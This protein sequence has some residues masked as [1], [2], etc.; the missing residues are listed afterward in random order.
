MSNYLNVD[1]NFK[2]NVI[3]DDEDY[4][5]NIDDFDYDDEEELYN[6]SSITLERL[7]DLELHKTGRALT[8]ARE[9]AEKE[10]ENKA[11]KKERERLYKTDKK[12]YNYIGE[13]DK[14]DNRI[15]TRLNVRKIKKL[16]RYNDITYKS[17]AEELDISK[18]TIDRKMNLES[19][20]TINEVIIISEMLG[21]DINELIYKNKH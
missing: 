8:L 14:T 2:K 9:M 11:R 1:D 16:L 10:A 15:Y 5:F 6:G 7:E 18:R 17:L 20:F 12:D 4:I 21:I 13:K 3:E 19:D